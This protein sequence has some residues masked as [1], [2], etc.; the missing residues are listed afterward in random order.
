MSVHANNLRH[1]QKRV[2]TPKSQS[3]NDLHEVG[4]SNEANNERIVINIGGVRFE[5]Y[6]NTLK[7]IEDSRLAYMSEQNSDYDP[8]QNEYFFDRDPDSFQAILNYFR[9]GKLH[10]PG[11]I[12]GN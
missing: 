10:A 4:I 8:I 9:T 1:Y 11:E 3:L 12:C 2:P 6:K 5:T 7:F